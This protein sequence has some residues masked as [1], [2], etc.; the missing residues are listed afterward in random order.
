M[1]S[2]QLSLTITFIL[3]LKM[4]FLIVYQLISFSVCLSIADSGGKV[5]EADTPSG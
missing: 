3:K 1:H 2:I 4:S 5:I